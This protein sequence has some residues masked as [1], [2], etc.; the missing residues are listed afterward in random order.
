VPAKPIRLTFVLAHARMGGA[1]RAVANWLNALPAERVRPA[2]V[3]RKRDGVLLDAISGHVPIVD[4]GGRRA[5]FCAPALRRALDA[6]DTDVAFSATSAMNIATL[7]AAI[8]RPSRQVIVSE[9]TSPEAYLQEAKWR[10]LRLG[11]IRRLY[12][13]AAAILAPTEEICVEIARLLRNPPPTRRLANP[14]L[15]DDAGRAPPAREPGLIVAAGRLGKVKGLDVLL[16][17]IGRPPLGDARLRIFGSGPER[18]ALENLARAEGVA[19]RVEFRGHSDALLDEIARASVFCLPSRREGFGNVLIEAQAVATPI[20]ASDLPGPRAILADG[21]YGRLVPP[22]DP[23]ALARALAETLESPPAGP[24]RA[25]LLEYTVG[26]STAGLVDLVDSVK[27]A[28]TQA[29]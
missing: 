26:A 22:G 20:V 13:R 12:P 10:G 19:Q 11:L 7:V 25:R 5:A 15:P 2:L 17:A 8:G 23:D 4:L 28:R 1:E 9:H 3:L 24:D 29:A 6:L 16:R 21:R 27:Q 18:G 14:V